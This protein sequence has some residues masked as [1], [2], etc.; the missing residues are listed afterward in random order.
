MLTCYGECNSDNHNP[1]DSHQQ[2]V[3]Y[4]L[5]IAR[6]YLQSPT[7]HTTFNNAMEGRNTKDNF[8]VL[9]NFAEVLIGGLNLDL[10]A[11]TTLV[12]PAP[13]TSN[14]SRND[15]TWERASLCAALN[16]SKS[17]Q[18]TSDDVS[19]YQS[20]MQQMNS[21]WLMAPKADSIMLM[22]SDYLEGYDYERS[23]NVAD[24]VSLV[25]FDVS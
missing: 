5:L 1:D 25:L 17:A 23:S 11:D 9:C 7:K 18:P 2:I 14:N 16:V 21:L 20:T 15:L 22:N 3:S 13:P 12:N 6:G 8:T 10:T 24:E 4:L 19:V